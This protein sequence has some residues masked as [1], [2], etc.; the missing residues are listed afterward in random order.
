MALYDIP[1]HTLTGE[2]ASLGD[3]TGKTLLLVNVASKCGLTPQYEGLER[4][5]KTYG[6]RGFSVVGFPCN[7]FLGQEPGSAEEIQQFCSTT[8]GVTFPLMEK[9]D[10]NGEDRH[11]IYAELTETKDAEGNA[12]DI[13]W[14]F[15]KFLVSDSGEILDRFRPQVEP[16]DA[17]IVGAIEAALPA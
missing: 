10:V 1:I 9:I 4:L 17:T 15:E 13:T 14:N 7:Q 11:P 6:D 12:G 2:D 3:F 8:Y 16:E 5:Q